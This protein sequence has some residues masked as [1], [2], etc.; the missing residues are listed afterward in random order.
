MQPTAYAFFDFDGTV[1]RGDSIVAFSFWAC[2][3]GYLSAA[4]LLRCAAAVWRY[5][6]GRC[7]PEKAKALPVRFLLGRTRAEAEE[8]GAA[9]AKEVLLPRLRPEAVSEMRL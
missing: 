6:R 1:I 5:H 9:F 7:T 8:I 2:R 4:E 3:K